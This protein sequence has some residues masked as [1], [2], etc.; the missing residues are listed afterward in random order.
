MHPNLEYSL[1]RTLIQDRLDDARMA[2][3]AR[4]LETTRSAPRPTRL[5]WAAVASVA[6]TIAG[7]SVAGSALQGDADSPT[8]TIAGKPI[9]VAP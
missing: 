8:Q 3:R 5:R 4:D 2:E 1:A 6:L 7:F 9:Q